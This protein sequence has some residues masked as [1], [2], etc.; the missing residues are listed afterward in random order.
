MVIW[1]PQLEPQRV[2]TPA[3]VFA[4][5]PCFHHFHTLFTTWACKCSRKPVV[6]ASCRARSHTKHWARVI[7][8]SR[9]GVSGHRKTSDKSKG[10]NKVF[11]PEA[12][13]RSLSETSLQRH[14][15]AVIHEQKLSCALKLQSLG[16]KEERNVAITLFADSW[17]FKTTSCVRANLDSMWLE[18]FDC[19]PHPGLRFNSYVIPVSNDVPS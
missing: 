13:S 17:A 12:D 9:T 4:N 3:S 18:L 5:A 14:T 6:P 16:N 19:R 2:A 11:A 8:H 1:A 10:S 15:R 7:A